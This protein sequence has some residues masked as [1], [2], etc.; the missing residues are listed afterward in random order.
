MAPV[1]AP[2]LP[3]SRTRVP[4]PAEAPPLGLTLSVRCVSGSTLRR[5]SGCAFTVPRCV[6]AAGVDRGDHRGTPGFLSTSLLCTCAIL[7]VPPHGSAPLAGG[8]TS[9]AL[10]VSPSLFFLG[11]P[12]SH[13]SCR[14]AKGAW[15]H[16]ARTGEPLPQPG[17]PTCPDT[18]CSGRSADQSSANESHSWGFWRHPEILQEVLTL[19][20]RS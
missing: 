7:S 20:S 9:A 11:D 15:P 12:R 4:A 19:Q 14:W 13:S 8:L 5:R 3:C 17:R 18:P 10:P 6:W 2:S 16:P 1:G